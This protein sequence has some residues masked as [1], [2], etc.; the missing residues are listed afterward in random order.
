[1]MPGTVAQLS[2]SGTSS[3]R[4][5][6]V[7]SDADGMLDFANDQYYLANQLREIGTMLG[8]GF[9]S[10]EI[11][12]SGM[13]VNSSNS[14]RPTPIGV[15]LTRLVA[16]VAAGMTLVF[17]VTTASSLG[18]CLI[19][20][21]VDADFN[22]SSFWNQAYIDGDIDD[23]NSLG[24]TA[25]ISGAGAHK[26]ALTFNRDVGGGDHEYA[27]CHDGNAA[28]TQTVNYAAAT[29]SAAQI[30]WDGAADG[31]QLFQTYI[32]SITFYPALD[33]TDLPALTA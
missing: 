1:M 8:G 30:G 20:I 26:I 2:P 19:Y 3:G 6:W 10:G 24:I 5:V 25:T 13:Y 33:P 7:Q 32:K 22:S 23:D 21:G 9:D 17:D 15:L 28:V 31:R 12:A 4:P 29:M 14:N 18:G 16:G 11:S 27:W